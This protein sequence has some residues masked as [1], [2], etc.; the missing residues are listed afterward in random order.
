M[1]LKI[2]GFIANTF[3]RKLR[4]SEYDSLPK[5]TSKLRSK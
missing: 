4:T 5:S 2:G 3:R 1:Y